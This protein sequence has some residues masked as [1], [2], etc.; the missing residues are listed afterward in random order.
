MPNPVPLA[1]F[2]K[3]LELNLSAASGIEG[4]SRGMLGE[5]GL[6]GAF[7]IPLLHNELVD[8]A[9]TVSEEGNS[10][11]Y[12]LSTLSTHI[13]HQLVV[14]EAQ[15]DL[16]I[17]LRRNISFH[18]VRST[19]ETLELLSRLKS[20]QRRGFSRIHLCLHSFGGSPESA[21]EVQRGKFLD[22]EVMN[23]TNIFTFV[24]FVDH[25][26]V[27]FSFATIISGRSPKF[28]DLVRMIEPD[29]ILLESDYDSAS[30]LDTQVM[31]SPRTERTERR[32]STRTD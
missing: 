7:K 4:K 1:E 23:C 22:Y 30:M 27:F 12:N 24:S 8:N 21:R 29:R 10:R 16:A 19:K 18:S 14:L 2:L 26:N 6:D 20:D 5:V 31:Y 15:I 11:R 25:S 28:Y 9:A 17:R 32:K 3:E 13:S